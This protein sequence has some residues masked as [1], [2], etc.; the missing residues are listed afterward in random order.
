LPALM[1]GRAA[2][3]GRRVAEGG[4]E[5]ARDLTSGA[6]GAGIGAARRAVG[7]GL[8]VPSALV[9]RARGLTRDR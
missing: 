6:A 7:L 9:E 2:S 8:R 4:V 5:T 3:A 1:V